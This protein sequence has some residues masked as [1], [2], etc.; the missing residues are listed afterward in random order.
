MDDHAISDEMP[1]PSDEGGFSAEELSALGFGEPE[2]DELRR[3]TLVTRVLR[4]V[5]VLLIVAALLSY[6][7]PFDLSVTIA[8]YR[9]RAPSA[10]IRPIPAA[11]H[12]E[13]NPNRQV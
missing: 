5:G 2:D 3:P 8:R 4:A 6:F 1:S 7:I 11:P 13:S 10:R 9:H 12:R